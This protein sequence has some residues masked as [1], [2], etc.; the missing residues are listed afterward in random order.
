MAVGWF[1]DALD[2]T[3]FFEALEALVDR[4]VVET[5]KAAG[6]FVDLLDNTVAVEGAAGQSQQ[7]TVAGGFEWCEWAHKNN[8]KSIVVRTQG[9]LCAGM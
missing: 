1:G 8:G 7:N 6:V 4:G 2:E 3:V 5:H 9:R